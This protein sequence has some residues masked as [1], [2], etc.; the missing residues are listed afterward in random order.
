M[1]RLLFVISFLALGL[2]S[3]AQVFPEVKI[4]TV[5]NST[6]IDASTLK[7]DGP[8]VISFWATWC[9][10]CKK[11]LEALNDYYVDLTEETNVK[12]YA[13]SVDD[14]RTVG[15]V[16]NLVDTRGWEYEIYLD[17][18]GDLQRAMGVNN[19]PHTLVY[20]ANGE[21]IYTSNAYNP[22]DEHHLMEKIR[23]AASK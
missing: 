20:S 16:K 5:D 6:S 9:A 4:K 22:G 1:R 2:T 8:V 7:H 15:L 23:E 10:P 14:A 11:E 12:V 13:I 19:V 3:E 21:L 17:P 18:N